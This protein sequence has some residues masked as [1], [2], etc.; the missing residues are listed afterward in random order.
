MLVIS[1]LGG[2]LIGTAVAVPLVVGANESVKIADAVYDAIPSDF[3]INNLK[4]RSVILDSN[5]DRI[6]QF[7]TEDR[8]PVAYKDI[9]Q[10]MIDAVVSIEDDKFFEHAGVMP[11]SIARAAVSNAMS[12]TTQGASTLTQQYVKNLHLNNAETPEEQKAAVEQSMQRKVREIKTS[13]EMEQVLTKEEILEGYL[14]IVNFGSAYGVESASQYY[15]SVPA[16]KLTIPQAATLAGILKSPTAYNPVTNP[17]V[18]LER[19]NVVLARMLSLEV[20]SEEQYREFS[21]LPIGTKVNKPDNGCDESPYPFYCSEVLKFLKNSP[22][23]GKTPE[24]RTAAIKTGGLVIRTPL[25]PK[26]QKAATEAAT[27]ALGEGNEYAAATA[28]IEPGTGMVRGIGQS[29]AY[30]SGADQT[31]VVL[32]TSGFQNGSTFKPITLIAALEN[33]WSPSRTLYSSANWCAPFPNDGCFSNMGNADYGRIDA[34]TAMAVSANTFFTHQSVIV[35]TAKVQQTARNLGVPIPDNTTGY[36][37]S[38]TLG[39][40]DVSPVQLANVYATIA[41]DGVMCNPTWVTSVRLPSG[42]T[43]ESD[44]KCH[45]AIKKHTAN[46]VEDILRDVV[47]GPLPNRT[48]QN[49]SIGVPTMGKTGTTTSAAAVWFAGG[50][51]KYATATWLGDPQG[52]FSNPIRNLRLYGNPVGAAFGSTAAGPIWKDTMEAII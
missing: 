52:G 48:G 17:Q 49:M 37:T 9:S 18:S 11:K 41:A 42:A 32:S 27:R 38:T 3:Q 39:V 6:A 40:Y 50:T 1:L 35:G 20:I 12:D 30:G 31:Q 34:R 23:L 25:Q 47:D 15:F 45:Q 51:D 22:L 4:T 2:L 5:G 33:G 8:V 46:T 13:I 26:V 24:E 44:P 36:E 21:K 19:R 28:V 14:N 16:S 10:N 29:R 43:V 7:F